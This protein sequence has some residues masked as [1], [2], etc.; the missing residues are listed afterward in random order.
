MSKPSEGQPYNGVTG[1]TIGQ[2]AAAPGTDA[3]KGVIVV[4][5]D[6]QPASNVVDA[7]LAAGFNL[8]VYFLM[9]QGLM[10]AWPAGFDVDFHIRDLGGAN[11]LG[12]PFNV[13]PVVS[14]DVPP[15][16][17]PV[18]LGHFASWASASVNIPGGTLTPGESYRVTV[19]GKD[20]VMQIYGVHDSTIVYAH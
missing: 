16:A 18:I 3:Y 17:A 5:N 15:G 14:P 13:T 7:V 11:V 12:S 2:F 4:D 1:L 20:P 19:E 10:F 9:E 6:G 8:K